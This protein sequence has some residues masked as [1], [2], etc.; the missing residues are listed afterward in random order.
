MLF[1]SAHCLLRCR[2]FGVLYLDHCC[3]RV[4]FHP[5][6]MAGPADLECL[7]DLFLDCVK[8]HKSGKKTNLKQAIKDRLS[9]PPP[10]CPVTV[11]KPRKVLVLGSGGLSIGQAGEF[12]YCGSQCIKALKD[13]GISTVLINPNI[14]NGADNE[15][16]CYEGLFLAY[17]CGICGTGTL[18]VPKQ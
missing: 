4:Q 12:D 10:P 11:F 13:E 17:H 14:A 9:T 15:R 3:F 7:F 5:E 8:N 18:K 2:L 1:N 6:H 16:D